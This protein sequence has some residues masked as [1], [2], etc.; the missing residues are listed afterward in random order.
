MDSLINKSQKFNTSTNNQ[1]SHDN[2]IQ[3][4]SRQPEMT[5]SISER[6][7]SWATRDWMK[8][9]H[10]W[11]KHVTGFLQKSSDKRTR[12]L[13][14]LKTEPA[15]T[16]EM[17][18]PIDKTLIK[19]GNYSNLDWQRV[20][21]VRDFITENKQPHVEPR[22]HHLGMHFIK[23]LPS[24]VWSVRLLESWITG[25]TQRIKYGFSKCNLA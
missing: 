21:P 9:K 24:E 15:K 11:T 19:S 8:R 16:R 14:E 6:A 25:N 3:F 20:P 17:T 12:E 18:I 4:A 2:L 13:L 10:Q 7:A 5:R 22:F 23:W 1:K